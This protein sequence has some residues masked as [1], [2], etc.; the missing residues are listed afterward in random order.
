V[1]LAEERALRRRVAVKVL[2]D[3]MAATVNAERFI[4]EIRVCAQL[5]HPN[6]V[7]VYESGEVG[8]LPYFVMPFIDGETLRTRLARLGR[9]PLSDAMG[10]AQDV[11]RALDFAHR[12]HIVHRDIKPENV[13]LYRGRALVLDF[14]IAL[15]MDTL[16]APRHTMPG[17]T[18]GTFPY[19]SPEQVGCESSV[20]G[21]SDIYSLACVVYEMLSG[22]PPFTGSP[23]AVIRQHLGARPRP[24][25]EVCPGPYP[26][27]G[28]VL[29]RALGKEP[30][31]RYDSAASFISALI[32]AAP[33]VRVIGQRVAVVSFTNLDPSPMIDTFSDGIGEE[34]VAA[35]RTVDGIAVVPGSSIGANRVDV[36]LPEIAR[37]LGADVLLFGGVRD[38]KGEGRVEL[39]AVLIDGRSGRTLW[40]GS[41]AGL[42]HIGLD[43][44]CE[45]VGRLADAVASALGI[46]RNASLGEQ[47]CP[48]APQRGHRDEYDPG[49][50]EQTAM[51]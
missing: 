42:Y 15:A 26:K 28:R 29:S 30:G 46:K 33:R 35:L 5:R 47:R 12:H 25:T 13:M 21:R 10:I 36:H 49:P 39:C 18:L 14:G 45:P 22:R 2:R 24:L 41:F 31:A 50:T 51:R 20:D 19:M 11:A 38:A 48:E 17:L 6:I 23:S 7:P 40:S 27:I 4:A 9:L 34:V 32:G 43:R 3:E 1:Y 37:C 8:G 16:E 44:E